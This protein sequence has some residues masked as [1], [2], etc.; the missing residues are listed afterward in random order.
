L[1]LIRNDGYGIT[2]NVA[3]KAVKRT[4]YPFTGGFRRGISYEKALNAKALEIKKGDGITNLDFL[5]FFPNLSNFYIGSGNLSN[6]E[7][8]GYAKQLSVLTLS[9]TWQGATNIQKLD[10]LAQ[11]PEIKY[12]AL[13]NVNVEAG[14]DVLAQ[15]KNLHSLNFWD[16]N[17]DNIDF[18]KNI[19]NLMDFSLDVHDRTT[20][21][22]DFTPF[23]GHPNIRE[24]FLP[25]CG[26]TDISF[27]AGMPELCNVALSDNKIKDFSPLKEIEKL[28]L[29]D[30]RNNG[31]SIEDMKKLAEE[32]DCEIRF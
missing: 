8:L 15:L 2:C 6:V 29:V 9:G 21:T 25:N 17:V 11:L 23:S 19:P 14:L 10:V 24:L 22:I 3:Y 26:I 27:L 28:I 30:V 13:A 7:G 31:Q 4:L 1:D 12:F 16:V 32:L 5:K 18:V 20:K